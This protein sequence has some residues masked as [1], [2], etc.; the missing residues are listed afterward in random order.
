LWIEALFSFFGKTAD[1]VELIQRR[2]DRL[3]V[4]RKER[5]NL[6]RGS[7]GESAEDILKP[8]TERDFVCP[9]GFDKRKDDC[10]ILAASFASREQTVLPHDG[11]PSNRS[12]RRIIVDIELGII[13]ELFQIFFDIQG[14]VD[15]LQHRGRWT[16]HFG[17]LSAS[18]KKRLHDDT[19]FTACDSALLKE[20]SLG[21]FLFG[22]CFRHLLDSVEIANQ[23]Q[24]FFRM[25][26]A[27]L[28]RIEKFA[29]VASFLRKSSAI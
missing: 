6:F 18:V 23:F 1:W 28:S 17:D 4:L 21:I 19:G 20:G 22:P 10:E 15:R 9:A 26:I 16:F 25:K 2:S 3:P 5:V 29:T 7:R 24:K 11:N 12:F 13:Q 14:I 8:D 27:G